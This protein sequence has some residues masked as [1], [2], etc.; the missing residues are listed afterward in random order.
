MFFFLN[1]LIFNQNNNLK[2]KIWKRIL[3]QRGT[4]CI[5]RRKNYFEKIFI[6][7]NDLKRYV[8]AKKV[9][10]YFFNVLKFF[11]VFKSSI[12]STQWNFVKKF[13]HRVACT[14]IFG[15]LENSWQCNI[16]IS[17]Q[18]LIS[19]ERLWKVW[20]FYTLSLGVFTIF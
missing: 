16:A 3:I 17:E 13:E 8:K 12:E 5:E 2:E 15:F 4:L 6:V 9:K 1:M 14:N 10:I 18:R 7:K 19:N 11:E 20:K